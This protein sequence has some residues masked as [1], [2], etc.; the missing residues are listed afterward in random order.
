M[1]AS[2][3]V[4]NFFRHEYAGLVA[5]LSRRVGIQELQSVED[6]VQSALMKALDS[7]TVGGLPD[8]PS[9]WVFRVAYNELIGKL[10]QRAGRHRILERYA[11]DI[12]GVFQEATAHPSPGELQ[13][14]LLRMLFVSCDAAIPPDSQLVL[15]LKILCGFSVREIALRLFC[16]EDNVYKR[17]GRARIRLR[18]VPPDFE[19][20]TEN[21]CAMRLP[22]VHRILYT[23]FTEGY[24]SNH[25]DMAIR[26]ELCLEAMRLARIIADHPIGQ[27]PNSFALLALMHLHFARMTARQNQTGGLLLLEEQDR[28]LW[29]HEGIQKGLKWLARSATGDCFSRYHAEAGIASEH[30]IAPSFEQTRWDKVVE[31]YEL[32]E[33]HGS[34]AVHRLNRAVAVAEWKDADAGLAVLAH[35]TPPTWLERSYLWAAVLAD[36]NLRAGK[37]DKALHYKR[38]ALANA[39]SKT[40]HELLSRRLTCLS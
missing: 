26:K 7:W 15:A 8:N 20:M 6:A 9:A 12:A 25:P 40:V 27:V 17:L 4:E 30:C 37:M 35:V 23:I 18:E 11:P 22:S 33:R 39:P 16:S 32:L 31:Y 19:N 36:L 2:R 29:D 3:L 10:R 14:D 38:E 24:L 34:S 1:R 21:Q 13:D 28:S 5:T